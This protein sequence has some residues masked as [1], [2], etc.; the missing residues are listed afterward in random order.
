MLYK[1]KYIVAHNSIL[2]NAM[3]GWKDGIPPTKTKKVRRAIAKAMELQENNERV[4]D[5]LNIAKGQGEY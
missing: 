3:D 2:T 5:I 4:T 1:I